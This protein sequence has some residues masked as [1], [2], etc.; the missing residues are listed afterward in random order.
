MR[1]FVPYVLV[2]FSG[3]TDRQLIYAKQGETFDY[4]MTDAMD[5]KGVRSEALIPVRG[6]MTLIMCTVYRHSRED[7]AV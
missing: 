5:T 7:S 4:T 3:P 2:D 1:D 6:E